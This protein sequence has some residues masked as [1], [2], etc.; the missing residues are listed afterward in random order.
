MWRFG[1][2]CGIPEKLRYGFLASP[3]I[4]VIHDAAWSQRYDEQRSMGLEIRELR[5]QV[6][7]YRARELRPPRGGQ[8]EFDMANFQNAIL[9][10]V[11]S[12]N[13]F[14]FRTSLPSPIFG[15]ER[16]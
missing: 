9:K 12:T 10:T 16:F 1:N 6:E 8:I 5:K 3:K 15:S 2:V 14:Y 7:W 4:Y 11:Q 13:R